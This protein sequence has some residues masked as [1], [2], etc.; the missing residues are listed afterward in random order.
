VFDSLVKVAIENCNERA[1][2]ADQDVREIQT[3]NVYCHGETLD[4]VLWIYQ[5]YT[6]AR[7]SIFVIG[8]T[9][10]TNMAVVFGSRFYDIPLRSSDMDSGQNCKGHHFNG[11]QSSIAAS[12]LPARLISCAIRNMLDCDARRVDGIRYR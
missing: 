8:E 10:T 12:T 6:S 1:L 2:H 4:Q 9:W 3:D 11:I 7:F 5:G